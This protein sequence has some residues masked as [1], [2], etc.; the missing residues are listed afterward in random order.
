MLN[1]HQ[2]M[3]ANSLE[4]SIII[5][6]NDFNFIPAIKGNLMDFSKR[7]IIT[8]SWN[9]LKPNLGLLVLAIVFIFALNLFLGIIQERLLE[10]VTFQSILFTVAAYLFQMGLNLGM[11]RICLNLI[12]NKEG[13]FHQLFGSFNLLIPYLMSSL[14]VILI[15]L[16]AASP[17]IALL[18]SSI[19]VDFGTL[20][21][22]DSL[23][24]VSMVIPL[25][26][27]FI[28]FVYISLRLQ[29]YDYY[30][31]DEE[32]GIIDAVK[33]S[34]AITKGYVMELFLLGTVMSI[35]VLISIIPLGA[36]LLISIPLATM[37]NTYVYEKLKKHP[38]D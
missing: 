32:C 5:N 23:E 26:I 31:V 8:S 29:F 3:S 20:P 12:H 25:L 9:I 27:I 15:L 16:A 33:K 37:V 35:I 30:L 19:S 18:L 4:K 28:P 2:V 1:N 14:F 17:G 21:T 38:K 36:G 11:L 24:G 6:I 7:E 22:I 13:E 10:D 34:A